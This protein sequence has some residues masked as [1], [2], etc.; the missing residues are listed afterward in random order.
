MDVLLAALREL[1]QS[2]EPLL[3]RLV[4]LGN[5]GEES[6]ALVTLHLASGT[7]VRGLLLARGDDTRYGAAWILQEDTG[8]RSSDDLVYVPIAAVESVTVH[9]VAAL[10]EHLGAAKPPPSRL[11]LQRLAKEASGTLASSLGRVIAF[12][13]D[14]P[15]DEPSARAMAALLKRFA[16]VLRDVASEALGKEALAAVDR[17]VL[18]AAEALRVAREGDALVVSAPL[19]SGAG[20]L[21]SGSELKSAVDDA[22]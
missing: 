6:R 9:G 20:G 15:A 13:P 11:E 5:R 17:V 21:P 16:G 22:L 3:Q 7:H 2:P 1:P 18:H 19:S 4:E 10:I 12:E 14:A 8:Q